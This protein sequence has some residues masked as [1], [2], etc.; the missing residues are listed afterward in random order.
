MP[1]WERQFGRVW[2]ENA[3]SNRYFVESLVTGPTARLEGNEAHHLLHVMRARPGDEVCLF[4]GSGFEFRA[5]VQKIGRTEVEFNIVERQEANRE[6]RRG[7]TLAVSLPKGDRQRWLVEKATELGV[8]RLVPL[9]TE[10]SVAQLVGNA[11]TR[12]RRT[13]IEASKQCGRNRLMEIG[14]PV[15]FNDFVARQVEGLRYIVHP[16]ADPDGSMEFRKAVAPAVA[17]NGTGVSNSAVVF[18]IGPE[19]GFADDEI[20]AA[21]SAGWLCLSLGSRILRVETAALSVAA[22]VALASGDEPH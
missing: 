1:H 14:E 19:G 16:G 7:V 11:T 21:A 17:S 20:H 22:W 18:A 2:F 6:L 4:D 15:R 9:V 12:L 8:A 13:V 5:S 3:M 10:R